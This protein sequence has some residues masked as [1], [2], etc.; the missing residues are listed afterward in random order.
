MIAK[1]C[2]LRCSNHDPEQTG[3]QW[4]EGGAKAMRISTVP[5]HWTRKGGQNSETVGS[6]NSKIRPSTPEGEFSGRGCQRRPIAQRLKYE[7]ILLD[8]LWCGQQTCNSVSFVWMNASNRYQKELCNKGCVA[9]HI[10]V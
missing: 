6:G 7:S 8:R 3:A 2:V 5:E 4:S 10:G 1:S 9:A